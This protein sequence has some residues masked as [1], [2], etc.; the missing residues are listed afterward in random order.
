MR[1]RKPTKPIKVRWED[2]TQM[3]VA[4]LGS[5]GRTTRSICI[6]TG[7]TPCQVTYRLAAAGIKRMDWRDGSSPIAK[8][9]EQA[10][11]EYLDNIL[12]AKLIRHLKEKGKAAAA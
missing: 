12:R 2:P 11:G 5:L 1:T 6:A 8:Y 4:R 3:L 9:A 7:F 10:A